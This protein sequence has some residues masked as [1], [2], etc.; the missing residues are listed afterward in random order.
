MVD[1]A[2]D[3]VV[4]DSIA[5]GGSTVVVADPVVVAIVAVVD[6]RFEVVGSWAAVEAVAIEA[7]DIVDMSLVVVALFLPLSTLHD[8]LSIECVYQV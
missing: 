8:T 1:T 6:N 4:V 3:M 5:V 2:V 7:V